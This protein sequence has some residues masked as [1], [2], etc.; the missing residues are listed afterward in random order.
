[1]FSLTSIKYI[2][3]VRARWSLESI[4]SAKAI[5]ILDPFKRKSDLNKDTLAVGIGNWFPVV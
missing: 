2:A 1:V 4:L 5:D 3:N